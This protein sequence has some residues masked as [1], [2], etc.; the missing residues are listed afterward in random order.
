[1]KQLIPM[2]EHGMFAD[3]NDTALVDSRFVADAFEKGHREV[4]RSIDQILS[5]DS[6]YSAEFNR[7]NFA[8]ISYT[9]VRGRKQR[10]YAMTRDG[11]TALVMGFTGKKAAR[12][13][14]FY[15]KRFNEME[16]FIGALVSAREQFPKLTAQIRLLHPDAKPY[17][18]SNECDMLNRIVIGMSAKQFRE[19]HGLEKGQS[20]RPYLRD[21]QIAMRKRFADGKV[22]M[23]Y[24]QFLGYEKGPD[25][26]PAVNEKEAEIVR[27]IYRLF[28]EGK[29]PFGI[30]EVLE[31]AAIPSPSGKSKWS[32]TTINSILRNEKYKG[33]ALLQKS[34]TVDFLMKTMKPNRGELPSYYVKESH[35]PI[36]SADE[37]DMV[38]AEIERRSRQGRGYSGNSIFSSKLF[39]GDCGG[40][41]GAKVW[42]SNDAYRRV[43]WQCNRKFSKTQEQCKTPHLTEDTIKEMFLKAYNRLMR[44]RKQ[45]IEDCELM[46]SLLTDCA[47]QEAGMEQLRQ[48]IEEIADMT[49]NLVRQNTRQ[50]QSQEA[51]N[52]K[53]N[54]LVERYEKASAKH[55]KLEAEIARRNNK[56]RQ[57]ASFIDHLEKAPA[58]LEEWDSQ[59][60]SL[61]L[62]KGTV[63]RD[64]SVAF[65]FRNGKEIKVEA[66]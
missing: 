48:E 14:E 58:S 32:V 5:E 16:R 22:S 18:Y 59:V 35:P 24:K 39:C 53:Y 40:L 12:F 4:L 6:G 17:H 56:A 15:I 11:F 34:F 49:Q 41:Y 47:E 45:L 31:A 60:W 19:A 30:K 21:N 1:M 38:Q 26:T 3:Y 51:Y 64:G 57:L 66:K 55:D 42:H 50:I 27:L 52:A 43:I 37:F 28:L 20:I 63:N 44:Q 36:I 13:K 61:L 29:T 25:G 2:D 62:E 23:A 46:K 65:E 8:P 54:A 33:D 7:C 9:D 10:C